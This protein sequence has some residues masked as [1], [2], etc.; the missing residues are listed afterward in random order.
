[1]AKEAFL[2]SDVYIVESLYGVVDCI[3]AL[4][5]CTGYDIERIEEMNIEKLKKRYPQGFSAERSNNRE[6]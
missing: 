5:K 6:E 3:K 1:M 4:C 2:P